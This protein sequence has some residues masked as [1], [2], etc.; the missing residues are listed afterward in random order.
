MK[1]RARAGAIALVT[2]A[3]AIGAVGTVA[4][5][6]AQRSAPPSNPVKVITKGLDGPFGIDAIRHR[7][8]LVAESVTGQVT[9]IDR[10]G[11]ST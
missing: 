6:S 1:A 4:P 8:F 7:G 9:R 3:G 11:G 2:A 10:T 5:A